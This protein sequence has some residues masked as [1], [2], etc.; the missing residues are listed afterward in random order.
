MS[1]DRGRLFGAMLRRYRRAA[2]LTQEALAERA[3]LSAYTISALERG[4][5]QTPRQD[6]FALLVEALGLEAPATAVLAG[7]VRTG[8]GTPGAAPARP[9]IARPPLV[10]RV[11]ETEML[12]RHLAGAGPPVLLLAGE[13][14]IGK[15]RLLH[16]ARRMAVPVGMEVSQGGCRPLG[17]HE[18]YAP[19]PEALRGVVRGRAP[20][21]LRS[22]LDGCAWLVRLLPELAAGPIPPLPAWILAPEQERHLIFETVARFLTNTA[23]PG[24]L[25]LL[26]DDLQWFGPD[27]VALLR[28]LAEAADTVRMR[29]VAAY[30]DTE[31]RAGDALSVLLADLARTGLA[32]HHRLAPLGREQT[33]QLLDLML[34]GRRDIGAEL[35]AS[36]VERS[37]GVPFFAVSCI[38]GLQQIATPTADAT[39]SC[40]PGDVPWTVAQSVRQR[41]AVL[42]TQTQELLREAAIVGRIVRRAVLMALSAS[43]PDEVLDALDAACHARLLEEYGPDAY[44]FAHDV[45]REVVEAD[46]SAARRVALHQRVGAVL[47][48]PP[49]P[50]Q[51]EALAYH[52]AQSDALEKAVVYLEQAGD[53]ALVRSAFGAAEGYY[54]DLA[55]RLEALG[56][57]RDVAY[58]YAKLGLLLEKIDNTAEAIPVL[59][60]ATAAVDRSQEARTFVP[61]TGALVDPQVA[62]SA[63]V[64]PYLASAAL[65][66]FQDHWSDCLTMAQRAAELACAAGDVV[67]HADALRWQGIAHFKSGRLDEAMT[68]LEKARRLCEDAGALG[69]LDT[70]LHELFF[71]HE[72]RGEFAQAER[73]NTQSLAYAETIGDRSLRATATF[74]RACLEIDI[75]AWERARADL[76][77]AAQT[78]PRFTH[79]A[80]IVS[81]LGYVSMLQGA[82]DEAAPL[83]ETARDCAAAMGDMNARV[84]VERWLAELELLQGRP[85]AAL[86]RL[87]VLLDL[88]EV[89]DTVFMLP[90]VAWAH[91]QLGAVDRAEA[92][93]IEAVERGRTEQTMLALPDA[94][95]LRALVATE[96]RQWTEA[97][98][99]LAEG[100]T[101]ARRMPYPYAEGRLLHVYGAMHIAHGA[102]E[103]AREWLVAALAIFR[104]LGARKDTE[105]VE[106]VLARLRIP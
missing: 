4:V 91:V 41:L 57:Q 27:A 39:I 60:R 33:A 67:M 35:G 100:L 88:D 75:G 87:Q 69:L 98:Q 76:E 78:A 36:I 28:S 13:P 26:L 24:G 1:A 92:V 70:V 20:D 73:C 7:A 23:G 16:E 71:L 19:F 72:L 44:R 63:R 32:A 49:G 90:L 66:H 3:S 53:Q 34:E 51:I 46:M 48:A 2:G 95:R 79:D 56:R 29:L 38:E 81:K 18:P 83:L 68:T 55:Q 17:G 54:R 89:H 58:A 37:G 85:A 96:Q 65:A 22:A 52:F 10:G 84:M 42:P 45:V 6:T 99:V 31:V 97:A 82:W 102:P 93:A 105:Q 11:H 8:A 77:L 104:R 106:H 43:S 64:E 50:R 74:R 86:A 40:A 59:Q 61:G 14:G 25:L 94:L 62:E 30:R 9:S 21:D 101:L 47:E 5:N 80:Y 12:E 103:P 15:S